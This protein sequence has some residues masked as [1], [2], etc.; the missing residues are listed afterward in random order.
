MLFRSA[1][2]SSNVSSNDSI[3]FI[4]RLE[5]LVSA[6][7]LFDYCKTFA[8]S[9]RRVSKFKGNAGAKHASSVAVLPSEQKNLLMDPQRWAPGMLLKLFEG[10]LSPGRFCEAAVLPRPDVSLS[11]SDA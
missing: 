7:Q 3:V 2:P 9:V 11:S 6:A 10:S 1:D 8:P 4:T 5:P